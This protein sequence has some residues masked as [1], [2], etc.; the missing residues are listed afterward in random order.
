MCYRGSKTISF[1][2][3]LSGVE[4]LGAG[5]YT[6]KYLYYVRT[7]IAG[8]ATLARTFRV[9]RVQRN[10]SETA[11]PIMKDIGCKSVT[12]LCVKSLYS[13][14][15]IVHMPL[16][17]YVVIMNRQFSLSQHAKTKLFHALQSLALV[18]H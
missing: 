5:I 1:Q 9:K 12:D 7:G 11:K 6:A 15:L 3:V 14:R 13:G 10:F 4:L 2:A 16:C 17:F 8:M 18:S